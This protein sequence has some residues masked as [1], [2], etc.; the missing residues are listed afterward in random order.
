[1]I[2]KG[3]RIYMGAVDRM[4]STNFGKTCLLNFV[5]LKGYRNKLSIFK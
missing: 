2:L 3:L 1:M 5:A 4:L